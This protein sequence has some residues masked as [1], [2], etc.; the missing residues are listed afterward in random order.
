MTIKYLGSRRISGLS[1]DVGDPPTF[2]DPMTSAWANIE[3][4]NVVVGSGLLNYDQ[5]TSDHGAYKD[6]GSSLSNTFVSRFKWN[7]DAL[8]EGSDNAN[9]E[10]NICI[11]SNVGDNGTYNDAVGLM[12]RVDS[13]Q[14][15]LLFGIWDNAT[16]AVVT[17]TVNAT[18][19]EP[20][21]TGVYYV[22]IVRRS[23]RVFILRIY[24]DSDYTTLLY[25]SSLTN[26][27]DLV[28]LRY[29]KVMT[30]NE[31][32]AD[33]TNNGSID[34]WN[35]YDAKTS[36]SPYPTNVE[37][38]TI[39]IDTDV[40]RWFNGTGW[41]DKSMY[42][43]F[44]PLTVV[45]K[46]HFVEWFSGKQPDTNIWGF[47]NQ[48]GSSGNLAS[49]ADEIDGGIKLL[50]GSGTNQALYMSFMTGTSLTGSDNG[51][52]TTIPF[53]PFS[54]VGSVMI[55]VWKKTTTSSGYT[56]GGLC[57]QGRGD[58]A[59]NN[60]AVSWGGTLTS[61]THFYLRTSNSG[62]SQ[63]E[64]NSTVSQDTNFHTHKIEMKSSSVGFSLDGGTAVTSTGN[65]PSS[66]GLAP[67]FS[68][69]KASQTM[70]IRYCEV[71]NT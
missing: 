48:D 40:R 6:T 15:T 59:G 56:A 42:E 2:S 57:Q 44:N 8:S 22:E 65:I 70:Q 47:G 49:M 5:G 26:S 64:V 66:T 62:G 23:N 28:A 35:I 51:T 53:K 4:S 27:A 29:L 18:I 43:S 54:S 55:S 14:T 45:G 30:N 41:G 36:L 67:M 10:V 34:D 39:F 7:V 9:N 71:Y 16:P 13:G 50:S 24:T 61:T 31:P 58:I 60:L 21:T 32:D 11:S 69:N 19:V 17:P 68:I 38:D 25:S 3:G 46:Q 63:T 20:L 52:V 33:S 37:T 12:L 1:T